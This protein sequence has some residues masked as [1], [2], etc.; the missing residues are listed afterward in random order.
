MLKEWTIP[1][2]IFIH[3][4][5]CLFLRE[6]DKHLSILSLCWFASSW[7]L[8]GGGCEIWS[9]SPYMVV[10]ERPKKGAGHSILAGGS[11]KKQGN[12][13][14]R[15]V[16]SDHKMSTSLHPPTR[17][18]NVHI[19]GLPGLVT[20]TVVS[21]RHCSLWEGWAGC[22]FQ[23]QTRGQEPL[24]ARIQLTGQPAITPSPGPPPTAG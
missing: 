3:F 6:L 18:V 23:G 19:E 24:I 21:V 12:F 11:F 22:A 16:P 8:R 17:I 10:K 1:C 9:W 2:L 5:T 20:Y 4:D 15:L 7:V 14:M 13:H